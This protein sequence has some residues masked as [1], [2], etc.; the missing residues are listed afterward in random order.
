MKTQER[1]QVLVS[2]HQRPNLLIMVLLIALGSLG[3]GLLPVVYSS[4][5]VTKPSQ[6]PVIVGEAGLWSVLGEKV[7]PASDRSDK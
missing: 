4:A 5:F 3:I 1:S 6:A 7:G 2:P